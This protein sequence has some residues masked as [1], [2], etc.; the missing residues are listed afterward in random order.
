MS[1][2]AFQRFATDD[3]ANGDYAF[4]SRAKRFAN[5]GDREN[6]SDADERIARTNDDAIGIVDRFE[7]A[8]SWLRVLY[9][10]EANAFD[11][12]LRAALYEIFLKV[13]R[14]FA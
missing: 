13:Q 1:L 5:S 11:D 3:R 4:A 14:A 2:G 10:V 7:D 6:R 12:W 8:R 9:T